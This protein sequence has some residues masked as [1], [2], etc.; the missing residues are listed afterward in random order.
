MSQNALTTEQVAH[1]GEAIYQEKIKSAV[2]P[3]HRGRFVAINVATGEYEIDDRMLPAL[4]RAQ[5]KWRDKQL[6]VKRV[7]Y[8]AAVRIGGSAVESK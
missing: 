8:E 2:E 3:K 1:R 6:Y 7:G 5:A 4:Q